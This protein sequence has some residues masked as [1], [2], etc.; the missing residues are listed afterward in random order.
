L[1]YSVCTL[2]RSTSDKAGQPK[3]ASNLQERNAMVR[4]W[5]LLRGL[6]L[7]NREPSRVAQLDPFHSPQNIHQR[8]FDFV[9]T[10]RQENNPYKYIGTAG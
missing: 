5:Y 4:K 9:V 10:C 3:S 8:L 7:P 1:M 6:R 2:E